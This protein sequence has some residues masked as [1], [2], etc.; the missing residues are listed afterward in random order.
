MLSSQTIKKKSCEIPTVIITRTG[1]LLFRIYLSVWRDA[2]EGTRRYK[3]DFVVEPE[4]TRGKRVGVPGKFSECLLS[5]R[6]KRKRG[7]ISKERRAPGC[8]RQLAGNG[9]V[10]SRMWASLAWRKFSLLARIVVLS[11]NDIRVVFGK[12]RVRRFTST[13]ALSSSQDYIV[14][15]LFDHHNRCG[16]E[17]PFYCSY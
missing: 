15:S 4:N 6:V 5:R 3:D 12:Y 17:R 7:D 2:L 13:C 1:L 14:G 8:A 11:T 16:T 9:D 10:H